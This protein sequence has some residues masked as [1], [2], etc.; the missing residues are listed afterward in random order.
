MTNVGLIVG[1]YY[2]DI[3]AEMET[4]ARSRIDE[5]DAVV[6]QTVDVNGVY[7]MPLAADRL[8]RRDDIDAVVA[9]AAVVTGD[10]DHDQVVTHASARTLA[11]ISVDRDTPVGFG[12]TGPGMSGAEAADRTSYGETAV[13]A[14]LD[15]H[16]QFQDPRS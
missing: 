6:E 4:T 16:E 15:L 10:T 11:Q 2:P 1:R 5:R 3:A 9:L 7:E 8:A 14:A 13:D 12:V